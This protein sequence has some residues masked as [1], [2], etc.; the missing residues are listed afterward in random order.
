VAATSASNAWAV[1]DDGFFNTQIVHWNGKR[2]LRV[3]TPNPHPRDSGLNSISAVSARD[4][5]AVGNSGSNPLILHW[6]GKTWRQVPSPALNG[7]ARGVVAL[8][9]TNAWIAG[10][11]GGK[12]LIEHWNGHAWRQTPV[13]APASAELRSLSASGANDVWAVGEYFYGPNGS[14]TGVLVEHWNGKTWRRVAAVNPRA[15]DLFGVS[16]LSATNAWAA[17]FYDNA[18]VTGHTLIEHWNG[19]AWTRVASPTPPAGAE[20]WAVAARSPSLAFAVGDTHPVTLVN[21]HT[22]VLRWDGHAWREV[23]SAPQVAGIM[24]GVGFG[25][26]KSVWIVGFNAS[27]PVTPAGWTLTEHWNGAAWG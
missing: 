23:T 22:Y 2:W 13:P 12:A 25:S 21:S 14:T 26:A 6:N 7:A 8:S 17:G 24:F 20:L 15:S 9:A 16:V 1:G 10:E 18:T 4:I 11:T 19:R 27:L 3:A 5:W